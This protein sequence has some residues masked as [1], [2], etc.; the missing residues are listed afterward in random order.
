MGRTMVDELGHC[1]ALQRPTHQL[2]F[3][4]LNI[5]FMETGQ[6]TS[7]QCLTYLA[8]C[9]FLKKQRGWTLEPSHAKPRPTHGHESRR[10][11]CCLFPIIIHDDSS[12]LEDHWLSLTGPPH[13]RLDQKCQSRG[14]PC[15]NRLGPKWG[16]CPRLQPL[17]SVKAIKFVWG[18]PEASKNLAFFRH[19]RAF[20]RPCETS[21]AHAIP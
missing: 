10:A 8:L 21:H 18:P 19:Y 9:C 16:T 15:P 1:R 6:L 13:T 5:R 20:E 2:P 14:R 7:S 17:A 11:A 3:M 12:F 4:G